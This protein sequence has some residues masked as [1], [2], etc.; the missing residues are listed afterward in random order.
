MRH[1]SKLTAHLR[2]LR[3]L[4]RV[5]LVLVKRLEDLHEA[6]LVAGNAP[7][8]FKDLVDVGRTRW[9]CTPCWHQ[10]AEQ[11]GVVLSGGGAVKEA[12]SGGTGGVRKV[13]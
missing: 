12:C 11:V 5:A 7:Q 13:S 10:L 6:M 1:V 9:D 3:E 8:R 2:Y 4:K